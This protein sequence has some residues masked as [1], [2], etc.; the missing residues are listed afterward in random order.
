[1]FLIT[2]LYWH[3]RIPI[4]IIPI[5]A[6]SLLKFEPV[7][8]IVAPKEKKA[9][10]R[11]K[12]NRYTIGSKR[13]QAAAQAALNRIEKRDLEVNHVHGVEYMAIIKHHVD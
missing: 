10:G 13:K 11:P 7:A 9:R 8:E 12:V 3:G 2:F 6:I 5:T 1:M 4:P